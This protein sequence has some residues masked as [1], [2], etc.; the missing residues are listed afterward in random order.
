M[1]YFT[2][3]FEFE[4]LLNNT[5]DM[6]RNLNLRHIILNGSIPWTRAIQNVVHRAVS[7][8]DLLATSL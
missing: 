8:Y 3:D 4:N 2:V 6:I 1:K 7:V 5:V